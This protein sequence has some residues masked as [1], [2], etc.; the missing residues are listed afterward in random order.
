ME[1]I[2][3]AAP[4]SHFMELHEFHGVATVKPVP[5][6]A[7]PNISAPI[8]LSSLP[9]GSMP[10]LF[11]F[12]GF[13]SPSAFPP[14]C[15]PAGLPAVASLTISVSHPLAHGKGSLRPGSELDIVY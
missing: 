2:G 8:P 15:P 7:Q 6:S 4:M 14:A 11:Q 9:P 1:R 12:A 5:N 10:P 13:P 3:K